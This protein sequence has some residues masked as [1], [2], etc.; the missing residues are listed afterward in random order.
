[1]EMASALRALLVA[2]IILMAGLAL[3]YLSR[4]RLTLGQSLRWGL[5]AVLLPLLGPFLVIAFHPGRRYDAPPAQSGPVKRFA[6][7]SSRRARLRRRRIL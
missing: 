6:S 2:T 4:R 1:M 7:Q 3:F 5:L